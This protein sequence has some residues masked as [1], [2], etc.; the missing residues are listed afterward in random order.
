MFYVNYISVKINLK[1]KTKN[2]LHLYETLEDTGGI[3]NGRKQTLDCLGLAG[4]GSECE[5]PQGN[6]YL[7][8]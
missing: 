7:L 2:M 8:G 4:A 6:L 3:C 5:G 1:N